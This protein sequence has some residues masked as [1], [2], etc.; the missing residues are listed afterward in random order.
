MERRRRDN[1]NDRIQE[2]AML[3]PEEGDPAKM[4]KGQVLQR[5]AE[6]IRYLQDVVKA[7][8]AELKMFNPNYE[9]PS[10]ESSDRKGNLERDDAPASFVSSPAVGAP[11]SME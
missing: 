10:F 7:Q 6:Y 3:V 8:T 4:H 1:I 11:F 2:L 9:P 5:S